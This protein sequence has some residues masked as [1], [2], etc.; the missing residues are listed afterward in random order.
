MLFG[1][2]GKNNSEKDFVFGEFET[3]IKKQGLKIDSVDETGRVHISQG[4]LTLKIGLD[5]LRK[6]YNR[7]KDK[8][9]ILVFVKTLVQ[10]MASYSIG[11]PTEWIA[12]KN[13]IFISLF[14]NQ[15]EF[16]DFVHY[17]VT[18]AISKVY[19]YN[20]QATL[21]YVTSDNL[22]KWGITHKELDEQASINADSRL[23]KSIIVIDSIKGHRLGSIETEDPALTGALLFAPAMKEKIRKD[24]GFPF[25]AVLPVRDLCYIF[26]EK[27]IH[28]F[29]DWI[30][31]VVVDEFKKSG[32]PVT[33]EILK[34]TDTGVETEAQYSVG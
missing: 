17:K 13:D 8:S 19:V 33:T 24:F 1:L 18:D 22:K 27:D 29:S 28:F 2:F 23:A 30:G 7:A 12:V 9:I 11:I 16:K 34:F 32:Y 6:E 21:N 14:P 3:E 31:G 25:Y 4:E 10:T 26:P 15:N 20:G 5:N